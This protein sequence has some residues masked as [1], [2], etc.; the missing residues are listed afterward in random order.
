MTVIHHR[1]RPILEF[2]DEP[3][4]PSLWM[5]VNRSAGVHLLGRGCDVVDEKHPFGKT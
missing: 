4:R 2:P 3:W 5:V 1:N